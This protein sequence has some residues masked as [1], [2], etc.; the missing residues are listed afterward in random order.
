MSIDIET[1]PKLDTKTLTE[2]RLV[3]KELNIKSISKYKK[4]ELIDL[5]KKAMEEKEETNK[6]TEASVNASGEKIKIEKKEVR[7]TKY[8]ARDTKVNKS[9]SVE[10]NNQ[11]INESK[12]RNEVNSKE[13]VNRDMVNKE[14]NS[15]SENNNRNDFNNKCDSNNRVDKATYKVNRS[16]YNNGKVNY[17][18]KQVE[19]SKIVDEF[20]T[21]KEDEVVGV[22]EILQDG[23]GFLRGSN[24]LSTEEDVY[25]KLM[26][27][28]L[29]L[30]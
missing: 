30:Q 25:K 10:R 16:N 29:I 28:I 27:K 11:N 24:Y 9:V 22:L 19:E 23:F 4:G 3:A 8:T 26:M 6:K 2:L 17:M 15:K 12:T 21:S 7:E 14:I 1:Q 18:P 13:F 20:N 5:I